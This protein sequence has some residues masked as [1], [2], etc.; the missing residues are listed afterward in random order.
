MT[1]D[2]AV[3]LIRDHTD[4]GGHVSIEA[5]ALAI[6]TPANSVADTAGASERADAEKDAA[7]TDGDAWRIWRTCCKGKSL[8]HDLGNFARAILA[9]NGEKQ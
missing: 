3:E 2:E 9:A 6:A 4:Y 5:L 8:I 7:L 1:Y